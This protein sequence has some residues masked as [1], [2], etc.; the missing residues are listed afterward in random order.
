MTQTTQVPTRF[1]RLTPFLNLGFTVR[2]GVRIVY[3]A[4]VGGLRAT[5]IARIKEIKPDGKVVVIPTKNSASDDT[6]NGKPRTLQSLK[7]AVVI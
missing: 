6:Y 1:Q 5:V 7:H 2:P 3:P 4:Q